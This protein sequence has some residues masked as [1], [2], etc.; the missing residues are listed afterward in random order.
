MTLEL[1][2]LDD[3]WPLLRQMLFTEKRRAAASSEV[4]EMVDLLGKR[5]DRVLDIPCGVGDQL[6]E[7]GRLGVAALGVDRSAQYVAEAK[8]RVSEFDDV[9]AAVGDMRTYS[10]HDRF[11][12]LTNWWSS[13]GYFDSADDNRAVAANFYRL[14]R[15]GGRL[16]MQL[17]SKEILAR[18]FKP[19]FIVSLDDGTAV[20][21]MTRVERD[22]S[23]V[24]TRRI[25][26]RLE[27]RITLLNEVTYGL[28]TYSAQELSEL[29]R[30]VGFSNLVAYG[31]LD[32][33]AF[34]HKARTLVLIGTKL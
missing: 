28:M 22:W 17:R 33:S 7:W 8:D 9:D 16:L 18:E 30:S 29:L 20:I 11:D 32:G 12:L 2:T 5:P 15:P 19:L 27:P 21:D 26:V 4:Q 3:A 25:H 23:W 24:V 34:D 6:V 14:L 1:G 13:F 10:S 31:G